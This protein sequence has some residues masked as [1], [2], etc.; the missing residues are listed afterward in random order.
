MLTFGGEKGVALSEAG[1]FDGCGD[2]EDVV[3]LGDG[4]GLVCRRRPGR[5]GV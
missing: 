5:G 4:E 2:V 1:G 3:A